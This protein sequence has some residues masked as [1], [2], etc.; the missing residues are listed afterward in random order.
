MGAGWRAVGGWILVASLLA[1]ACGGEGGSADS[2][3]GGMGG[4]PAAPG[5]AGG[6]GGTAPRD[7]DD[8]AAELEQAIAAYDTDVP[9]T[10]IL[11]NGAGTFFEA[12][13]GDSTGDTVYESASTSKWVAA[14]VILDVVRQSNTLAL[15][16]K[17]SDLIDFW[18]TDPD[19]WRSQVTLELLLSFTSGVQPEGAL[20]DA[21]CIGRPGADY[22][23]CVQQIY[24]DAAGRNEAPG[25]EFIYGSHHLQVA[26]LMA[27]IAAE[28]SG[29]SEVFAAFQTETGLFPTGAFDLPS[30]DNPRL[31]GG[32]HWTGREYVEFLRA[33]YLGELLTPELLTALFSD[34]TPEGEVEIVESPIGAGLQE[35]WHYDLG[36][37]FECPLSTWQEACAQARRHSSPG[38]YGAYPFIDFGQG[39]YG[40]LARQGSLG[41]FRD[42]LEVYRA[43]A[44]LID[45]LAAAA[46]QP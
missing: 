11:G 45:E 21:G 6:S 18:T 39:Y 44:P 33:L 28:A 22:A 4:A 8:L 27:T 40:I 13:H 15:A 37:W 41:S 42:G 7:F 10:L 35:T 17:A 16:T 29:F 36:N 12:S 38:A 5:G 1:P 20:S 9:F 24:D 34:H 19:D 32:M 43:F 30:E 31:G 46:P 23:E 3:L 14:T 26:G 25:T 2:N